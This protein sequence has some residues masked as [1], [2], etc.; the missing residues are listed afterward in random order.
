MIE[1]K[2]ENNILDSIL[3]FDVRYRVLFFKKNCIYN[4]YTVC[5]FNTNKYKYL[6]NSLYKSIYSVYT[7]YIQLL[8]GDINENYIEEHQ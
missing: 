2:T 8:K 5:S 3:A 7:I 4:V 1:R 6:N